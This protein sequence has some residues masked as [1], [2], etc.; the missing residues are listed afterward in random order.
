MSVSL[1]IIFAAVSFLAS[2]AG[3]VCGIGGGVLIKP[4]LDMF[5]ASVS[6]P[7]APYFPC[8]AIPW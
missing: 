5:G 6:C 4:I 2:V 1:Y 3:A 8:P 7:A